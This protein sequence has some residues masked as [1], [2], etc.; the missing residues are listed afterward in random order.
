M[1]TC[2]N[3]GQTNSGNYFQWCN[4]LTL[5]S[6]PTRPRGAEKKARKEVELAA[7]EKAKVAKRLAKKQAERAAKE[8]A[9]DSGLK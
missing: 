8:K 2:L 1:V 3:C 7:E 5:S 4:Y 6:R 9:I